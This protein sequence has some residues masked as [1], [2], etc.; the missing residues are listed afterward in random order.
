MVP[1][2]GGAP[3]PVCH[4]WQHLFRSGLN[5]RAVGLDFDPASSSEPVRRGCRVRPVFPPKLARLARVTA[6]SGTTPVLKPF[7]TSMPPKPIITT[8]LPVYP[9]T[10][11]PSDI[12]LGFVPFE[13]HPSPNDLPPPIACEIPRA[14][15]AIN[16]SSHRRSPWRA[17]PRPS[18]AARLPTCTSPTRHAGLGEKKKTP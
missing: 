18:R 6:V 12:A 15:G 16:R 8:S 13:P 1:G 4:P 10:W 17:S 5:Y 2:R 7:P 3:Q 9:S 11:S 14:E